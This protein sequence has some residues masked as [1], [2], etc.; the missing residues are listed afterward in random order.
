M[1]APDETFTNVHDA[2]EAETAKPHK[3]NA[4]MAS[5]PILFL[6][7]AVVEVRYLENL[8]AIVFCI[9]FPFLH[10]PFAR[11]PIG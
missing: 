1:V 10:K 3:K 7:E 2:A 8:F 9:S 5:R 4:I 6:R 11:L